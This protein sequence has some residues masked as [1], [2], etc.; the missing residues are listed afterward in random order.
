VQ[1][2]FSVVAVAL[3]MTTLGAGSAAAASFN[4]KKAKSAVDKLVCATPELSKADDELGRL[5]K[6]AVQALNAIGVPSSGAKKDSSY[7]RSL[8]EAQGHWLKRVRNS[9]PDAACML[10]AYK[11]RNAELLATGAPKGRVGTYDTDRASVDVL[12][13]TPGHLR[14]ELTARLD[15]DGGNFGQ[16]CGE[17]DVKNGK[18]TFIAKDDPEC[19]LRW[20]FAKDG[21]LTLAQEGEC[22]FG[23]GVTANGTYRAP[24]LPIAPAFEFCYR[25][26]P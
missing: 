13:V 21:K 8:R 19:Q 4:C 14:F 16:L 17:V 6:E 25:Y 12:E 2:W 18:G 1:R 9:C 11:K 23:A 22:G 7:A 3:A 26:D 24:A 20:S 5:F 10:A 15:D